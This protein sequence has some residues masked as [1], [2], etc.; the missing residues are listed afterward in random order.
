[1]SRPRKIAIALVATAIWVA[2]S[3]ALY[4]FVVADRCLDAGGALDAA[5]RMCIGAPWSSNSSIVA[6]LP[7]PAWLFVIGLPGVLVVALV[8]VVFRTVGKATNHAA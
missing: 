7:W 8:L 2:L 3:W 1:M 4:P 5:T 6:S